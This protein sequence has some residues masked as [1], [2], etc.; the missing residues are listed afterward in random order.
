MSNIQIPMD[1]YESDRELVVLMPLSWVHRQSIDLSIK[2]Y[3]LH[4][5]GHRVP[6]PL[7]DNLMIVKSDC[8]RWPFEQTIDLPNGIHYEKIHSK[9]T[10]DNV[11]MI[12]IPKVIIPEKIKL[13]IE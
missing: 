6:P 4:V 7:K 9:M 5:A 1:I 10:L 13:D 8:Y 11:L 2:E 3:Q 12:V